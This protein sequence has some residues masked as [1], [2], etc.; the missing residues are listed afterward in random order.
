MKYPCLFT[1]LGLFRI[2]N[3]VEFET[4]IVLFSLFNADS[5]FRILILA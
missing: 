5:L 1:S 3:L 4:L 2:C